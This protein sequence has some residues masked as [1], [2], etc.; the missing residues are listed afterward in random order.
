MTRHYL[1][2]FATILL[3]IASNQGIAAIYKWKNEEGQVSYGSLPPQGVAYQR[4]GINTEYTPTP[5]PKTKKAGPKSTK[6]KGDKDTSGDKE[7]AYTKE[8]QATLCANAKKD[9]AS[10]NKGGRLRVKQKDGS[11]NVMPDKN[12]TERMKTMQDMMKKHCK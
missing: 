9:I 1:T 3:L 12:K 2:F 4:M 8:Q 7:A 5:A 10:L 6:G 11:S